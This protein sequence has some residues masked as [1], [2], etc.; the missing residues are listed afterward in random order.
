MKSA[1]TY[2]ETLNEE[3]VKSIVRKYEQNKAEKYYEKQE[4]EDFFVLIKNEITEEE[5]TLNLDIHKRYMF[6]K[7]KENIKPPPNITISIEIEGFLR[8][9]IIFK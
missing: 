9:W 8:Y 5:L 1:D 6:F 3:K 4:R 2:D 7:N